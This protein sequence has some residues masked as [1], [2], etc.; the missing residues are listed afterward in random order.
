MKNIY[1]KSHKI[2]FLPLYF[3]S[4]MTNLSIKIFPKWYQENH[5]PKHPDKP[6]KGQGLNYCIHILLVDHLDAINIQF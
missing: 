5:S 4:Q 6:V 3:D 1:I 2:S